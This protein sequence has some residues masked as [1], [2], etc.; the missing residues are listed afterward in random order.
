MYREVYLI[1]LKFDFAL[2]DPSDC[3]LINDMKLVNRQATLS[4]AWVV[5]V[6]LWSLARIF[7][8][9]TWLSEYGISTKIFATIEI[10]SSL[11]YGISS[12]KAIAKHINKQKRL[13]FFWG[14]L[15][16]GGYITPDAYVLT[17]GRSMPTNFYIVIIFLFVLFGAYGVFAVQKALR[18]S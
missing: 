4:V 13:V 18:S 2:H 14:M 17:N 11:I 3:T 10:S 7:A 15:A 5:L 9:S 12:A 1:C 6:M 8:V 16:F